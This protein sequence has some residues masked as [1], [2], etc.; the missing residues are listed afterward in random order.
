MYVSGLMYP[1]L[2]GINSIGRD[3]V[4]GCTRGV[5]VLLSL[6]KG[7]PTLTQFV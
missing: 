4:Q 3:H 5:A 2:L 7:V 6:L 1:L